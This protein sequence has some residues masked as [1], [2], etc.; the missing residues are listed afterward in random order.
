MTDIVYYF[1]Q[2]YQGEGRI[3][4]YKNEVPLGSPKNWKEAIR[5]SKREY[6]K[7]EN[8]LLVTILLFQIVYRPLWI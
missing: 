2:E 8:R 5:L 4:Y 3:K 7:I 1:L 6:I